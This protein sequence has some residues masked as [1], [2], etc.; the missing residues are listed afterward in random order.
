MAQIQ[1]KI[2][3]ILFKN[4]C[5]HVYDATNVEVVKVKKVDNSYILCLKHVNKIDLSIKNDET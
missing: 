3:S 4:D 2:F 5:C 1:N